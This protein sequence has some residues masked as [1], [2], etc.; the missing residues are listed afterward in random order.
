MSVKFMNPLKFTKGICVLACLLSAV[1]SLNACA[2][3]GGHHGRAPTKVNVTYLATHKNFYL[4]K[5]ISTHACV[6]VSVHGTSI[7]QCGSCPNHLVL[8][9]PS[10]TAIDLVDDLFKRLGT[11]YA[12][13]VEADFV[14]RL[15]RKKV[16]VLG[17]ASSFAEMMTGPQKRTLLDL[18]KIKNPAV[19]KSGMSAE[20]DARWLE[21]CVSSLNR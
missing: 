5:E 7:S 15:V 14:G 9:D 16:A 12:S 20:E 18:K 4:N 2:T 13:Q 6:N 11:N 3:D 1:L 21:S 17:A 10:K 8:I 19:Y